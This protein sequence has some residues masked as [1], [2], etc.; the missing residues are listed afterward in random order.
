MTAAPDPL[1][2]GGRRDMIP[3]QFLGIPIIEEAAPSGLPAQQ[4]RELYSLIQAAI[5][6]LRCPSCRSLN[7]ETTLFVF[8]A[9]VEKLTEC[10][11]CGYV[12]EE[13]LDDN[14]DKL[15]AFLPRGIVQDTAS[16]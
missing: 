2:G 13:M 14:T 11:D 5:D 6:M 8:S 1:K 16:E 3:N 4:E 7:Y 12:H 15:L 10:R 9:G